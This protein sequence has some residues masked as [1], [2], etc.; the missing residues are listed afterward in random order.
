MYLWLPWRLSSKESARQC[1]RCKRHGFD[2]WVGK[3]TL[4]RKWQSI[5]VFLPRKSH[6]Q[7]S[8][9]AYSPKG[10][11]RVRRDLVTKPQQWVSVTP[12]PLFYTSPFC[13]G[14]HNFVF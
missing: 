13:L 4:R 12:I 3:I 11:K 5:P 10:H 14:N 6:E 1:R 9:K 7:R 8:M 2:P